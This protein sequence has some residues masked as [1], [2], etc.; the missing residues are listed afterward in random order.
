M[1][2]DAPF[3][4]D[5][6]DAP[7]GAEALLA[8]HF[9]RHPAPRGRLAGRQAG[10]G[11]DLSRPHRVRREIRAGGARTGGA[12]P[13]GAR[14]RLARPGP[15]RPSRGQRDA[16]AHRGLPR[17]P[18]GR[19]GASRPRRPARPSRAA[20]SDRA[21][22]GRLHRS[23]HAARA[24]GLLWRCL[25]RTDV[26][27]ADEGGHPRTDRQDDAA[28]ERRGPRRPAD[29]RRAVTADGH[30]DQLFRQ[31]AHV[32]RERLRLVPRP[33]HPRTPTCRSA[34]RACSGPTPRWRRWRGSTWRRCRGCRCS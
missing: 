6:A 2:P 23:S 7:A 4:A 10:H 15:L 33:D 1:T 19:G 17:L 31:S 13:L 11:G 30:G 32:G 16:R 26:A 18:A 27:P 34:A 12:R 24:G 5:V 28:C 22:H 25:L 29:A 3:Y 9:G 14:H 20:L 21:F 8:D